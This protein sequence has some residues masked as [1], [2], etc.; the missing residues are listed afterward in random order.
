MK[1]KIAGLLF[2]LTIFSACSS[3]DDS[4]GEE[5]I[6]DANY[7]P[8]S[9]DNE[10]NY[11]NASQQEGEP[12][13]ES[14]DMLYVAAQSNNEYELETVDFADGFMTSLLANGTLSKENYQLIYDGSYLYQFEGISPIEIPLNDV[15][16][17]DVAAS[18]GTELF[19][20]SDVI[21]QTVQ[22]IPLQ[23]EYSVITTDEGDMD[24][25]EVNGVEYE[26]VISSKFVLRLKISATQTI[27]G[28]TITVPILDTQDVLVGTNYYAAGVGMIQSDMV[29][30][31]ELEDFSQFPVELPFESSATVNSTQDLTTYTAIEED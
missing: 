30:S 15:V 14:T 17:Y 1:T 11:D 6:S 16:F 25:W 5:Q 2:L 4:T 9:V 13:M 8:L 31:Y 20:S 23:I 10:W 27:F 24:N 26:D 28:N 18:A 21:T 12:A 19:I 7:F 3:D 22:N 29:L